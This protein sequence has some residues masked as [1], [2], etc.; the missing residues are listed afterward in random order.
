MTEDKFLNFINDYSSKGKG[1]DKAQSRKKSRGSLLIWW[2]LGLIVSIVVP[3]LFLLWI[4]Y[5][6]FLLFYA[7][8]ENMI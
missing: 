3:A 1:A 2:G 5:T 8:R 7:V 6:I 4:P